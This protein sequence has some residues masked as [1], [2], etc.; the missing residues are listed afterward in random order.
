MSTDQ[1]MSALL[2]TPWGFKKTWRQVFKTQVFPSTS[3]YLW[4]TWEKHFSWKWMEKI[5]F[6]GHMKTISDK[7][8]PKRENLDFQISC[9]YLGLPEVFFS[10]LI[11]LS[12]LIKAKT[13]TND[14][15]E[16][17]ALW[18][19]KSTCYGNCANPHHLLIIISRWFWHDLAI[20]AELWHPWPAEHHE[21]H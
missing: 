15:V 20:Y 2:S 6:V 9:L 14:F 1:T 4:K 18:C 5:N 16:W 3:F 13:F 10:F 8:L 21:N 17:F 11:Y 12:I 7:R 19:Y